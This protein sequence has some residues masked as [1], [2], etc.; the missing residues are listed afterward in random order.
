MNRLRR[1]E[2][3]IRQEVRQR[4]QE[5]RFNGSRNDNPQDLY[6]RN[7][8]LGNSEQKPM[9]PD[10][11]FSR[12]DQEHFPQSNPDSAFPDG[13]HGEE[14]VAPSL[15][16]DNPFMGLSP[17][18]MHQPPRNQRQTNHL[19]MYPSDFDET[20]NTSYKKVRGKRKRNT[21]RTRKSIFRRKST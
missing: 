3:F 9:H 7:W 11:E 8:S 14:E 12:R 19:D 5:R 18:P 21:H 4:L 13:I 16:P 17:N 1:Y 10:F 6:W 2:D 15:H 20:L